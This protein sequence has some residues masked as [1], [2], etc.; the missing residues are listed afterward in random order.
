M[1][2][3][4]QKLKLLYIMKMLSERT[5]GEHGLT[6]ADI[7]QGLSEYGIAAERKSVYRDI[8]ALREFGFGIAAFRRSPVEYALVDRGV[9]LDDLRLV[10]NAVQSCPQLTQRKADMLMRGLVGLASAFDREQIAKRLTVEERVKTQ[11][12]SLFAKIDRI[13]D[14]ISAQRKVSFRAFSFSEAKEKVLREGCERYVETPVD[15]VS[16]NGR[17][18][19]V[20][21]GDTAEKPHAFR[22]DRM[23]YVEVMPD[24]AARVPSNVH[25]S[26]ERFE[27]ELLGAPE[28]CT[29]NAELAVSGSAM[30]AVIDRFDA[31]VET[32][33]QEDGTALV[34]VQV[35]AGPIFY[36]WLATHGGAVRIAAPDSLAAGYREHLQKAL[37]AC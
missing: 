20:A 23:D 6:M 35:V 15:V 30:G 34:K 10:I 24:E 32:S 13:Q 17:Y 2:A 12:D 29:V 22:I 7:L 11:S 5:D 8:E 36:G 1:A 18:Y 27:D 21:L 37:A 26:V 16:S 25:F 19:L 28:A 3:N 31:D 9:D 14:A 33:V 4:T